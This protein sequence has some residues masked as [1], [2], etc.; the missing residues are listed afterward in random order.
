MP[1]TLTSFL[2]APCSLD[3]LD[4]KAAIVPRPACP[5]A[6]ALTL[7]SA[8]EILSQV[9]RLNNSIPYGIWK[10]NSKSNRL[11]FLEIE[12]WDQSA[13]H[14]D[15]QGCSAAARHASMSGT[16]SPRGPVMSGAA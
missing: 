12:V 4:G 16:A 15:A 9:K 1:N 10:M 3:M 5:H 6:T 14:A 11:D 13:A 2:V 8:R 7:Q